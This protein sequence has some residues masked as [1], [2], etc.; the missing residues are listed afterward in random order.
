[1]QNTKQQATAFLIL[2]IGIGIIFTVLG[3][4]KLLGGN[5]VWTGVGSAMGFVGIKFSPAFWGLMATLAELVGGIL[6]I[7]GLFTRYAAIALLFTMI[8]A[9]ILK[10]AIDGTFAGVSAPLTMLLIMIFFAIY[11]SGTNSVD[12]ARAR[13]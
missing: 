13:K 3:I 9:V 7:I 8:I 4:Q 6:L 11:G 1:M 10:I 5:E 12:A 2:R